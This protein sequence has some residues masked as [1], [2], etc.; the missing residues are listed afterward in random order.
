MHYLYT[1]TYTHTCTFK[2]CV[3]VI[4]IYIYIHTNT[5]THTHT[6]V[7]FRLCCSTS[8]SSPTL[9]NLTLKFWEMS[10]G[11]EVRTWEDSSSGKTSNQQFSTWYKQVSGKHV[12]WS[13]IPFKSG[14]ELEL[15][16]NST[17]DCSKRIYFT[18]PVGT[19]AEICVIWWSTSLPHPAAGLQKQNP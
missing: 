4:R 12:Q 6:P 15:E 9:T 7:Y 19:R 10:L 13:K 8:S 16:S 18:G 3:C 14:V 2:Y 5:H 1:Q 17:R 11:R